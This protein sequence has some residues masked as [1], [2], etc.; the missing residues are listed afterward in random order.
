MMNSNIVPLFST[1][2]YQGSIGN[3]DEV[4]DELDTCI[5][6]INFGMRDGWSSTHY[7]SDPFFQS[8]LI[9]ESKLDL[10]NSEIDKHIK[11]YCRLLNLPDGA[12]GSW[13]YG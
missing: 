13:Q 12:N 1:P 10:F 11:E 5:K 6:D 8:N 4:Q 9:I 2:I 3:Y 7:L